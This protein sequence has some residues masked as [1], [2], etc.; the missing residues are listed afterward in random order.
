LTFITHTLPNIALK[1]S[2]A[3]KVV[4]VVL[5][6][7]PVPLAAQYFFAY[8]D[9]AGFLYAY[10]DGRIRRMDD[11]RVPSYKFG[12]QSVAFT[13]RMDY[14]RVSFASSSQQL[15]NN[16]PTSYEYSRGMLTFVTSNNLYAYWDEKITRLSFFSTQ[17]TTHDSIVCFTDRTNAFK[18]FYDG[19][20]YNINNIPL[21]NYKATR[22]IAAYNTNAFIFKV[23]LRGKVRTLEQYEV[24]DYQVGLN[25]VGYLDQTGRLKAYNSG[26]VYDLEELTPNFYTVA[27]DIVAYHN[28]NNEFRVFY[29]DSSY[30]V[31]PYLPTQY[32]IQDRLVY[33]LDK[34]N[35]L[36]VFDRGTV[37]YVENFLPNNIKV[38]NSQLYFFSQYK[39]LMQYKD[40]EVKDISGEMVNDYWVNGDLVVY[41][42]GISDLVFVGREGPFR[43]RYNWKK[44]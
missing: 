30:V 33:Y 43:L 9:T 14:F 28:K 32:W 10:D 39:H 36:R 20:I 27:D 5:F 18:I 19:T 24:M 3:L 23:F 44:F 40:G 6:L 16:I 12:T 11:R 35:R 8:T 21:N 37:S 15:V 1:R 22:N 4:A 7:C 13:T 29:K 41:Q 25:T 17:H 42:A 34:S 26:T 38:F 2:I 31:E